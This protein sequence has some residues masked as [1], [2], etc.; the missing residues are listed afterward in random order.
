MTRTKKLTIWLAGAVILGAAA[1]TWWFA[2]RKRTSLKPLVISGVVLQQNSDPQKQLPIA[3]AQ[4]TVSGGQSRTQGLS[5]STGLFRLTLRP[6]IE[7]TQLVTVAITHPRYKPVTFEEDQKSRLYVARMEPLAPSAPT[8]KVNQETV[9]IR[10]KDI[11]VRYSVKEIA[12]TNV[13][14]EA[15]AFEVINTGNVPCNEKPPCSPDGKWKATI[16]S[17]TLDAGPG[18]QLTNCRVSCIAGPCP[19]TQVETRDLGQPSRTITVS[20]RNWSD[21]ATFLVEAEV[22]HTMVNDLVRELYPVQFGRTMSFTL[23]TAA[24]GP[25]ILAD[26]NGQEIVFPLGPAL[27]L[28]WAACVADVSPDRTRL[29]QCELK[30]GYEFK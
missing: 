25:S 12:T 6:G 21:T 3:N 7:P 19:F 24:E 1:A 13:G 4:I 28:S 9:A 8:P 2:W 20:V 30:P 27:R 22:M 26:M 15:K 16:G 5:D 18:N 10:S 29:Y 11:R 23:P 14:S 17:A